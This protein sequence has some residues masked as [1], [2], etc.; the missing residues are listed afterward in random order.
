MAPDHVVTSE[1]TMADSAP[2]IILS[3]A[4]V[5]KALIVK[6]AKVLKEVERIPKSGFNDQHKYNFV[7]ESDVA[8][9]IRKGLGEAGVFL[10]VTMTRSEVALGQTIWDKPTFIANVEV[11][12]TFMDGETGEQLTSVWYGVAHDVGDKAL[13]K[14]LTGC[15]KYFLLNSFLMSSGEDPE[16]AG[17]GDGVVSHPSDSQRLPA[18]PPK[19]PTKPATQKTPTPIPPTQAKSAVE[20]QSVPNTATVS[21]PPA[22]PRNTPEARKLLAARLDEVAARVEMRFAGRKIFDDTDGIKLLVDQRAI[23]VM[24]W[25]DPKAIDEFSINEI[26]TLGRFLLEESKKEKSEPKQVQP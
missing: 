16:N 22:D 15:K 13:Y 14:A 26:M 21:P 3:Q 12:F 18:R 11:Q 8:D 7:T 4:P 25:R 10:H 6:L 20:S 24:G 5:P 9:A 19:P 23:T 1:V 17:G 2:T